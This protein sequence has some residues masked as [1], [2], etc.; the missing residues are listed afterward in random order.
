MRPSHENSDCPTTLHTGNQEGLILVDLVRG[1]RLMLDGQSH[2]HGFS[3]GRSPETDLVLFDSLASRK[4][5]LLRPNGRAWQVEDMASSNGT[6]L[7]GE[8]VKQAELVPG[9]ILQVGENR[10]RIDD[11]VDSLNP[12]GTR[13]LL[14]KLFRTHL[15]QQS[16]RGAA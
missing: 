11:A 2:P 15:P 12:Q 4:H 14:I 10:F 13:N 8:R 3:L 9:D 6:W 1:T 7:N 16:R 5:C